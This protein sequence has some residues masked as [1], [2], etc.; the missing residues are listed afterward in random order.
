MMFF[1]DMEWLQREV[2]SVVVFFIYKANEINSLLMIWFSTLMKT[3]YKNLLIT[4]LRVVV[5]K[6]ETF[7]DNDIKK[8]YLDL[9]V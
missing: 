2:F 1:K 5:E 6:S 7:I 8:D 9:Q 4:L 3:P